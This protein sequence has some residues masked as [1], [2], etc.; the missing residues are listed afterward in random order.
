MTTQ[1]VTLRERTQSAMICP[2][3]TLPGLPNTGS[4][5]GM[6]R[7]DASLKDTSASLVHL[8]NL[9]GWAGAWPAAS[10]QVPPVEGA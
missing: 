9:C 4:L 3:T 2:S 6:P 1:V 5:I 7:I 10:I 8:F